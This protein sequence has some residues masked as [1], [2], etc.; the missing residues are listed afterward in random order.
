MAK[1]KL[2]PPAGLTEAE[3]AE[4]WY[5]HRDQTDEIFDGPE[6]PIE[7]RRNVTISVR[8]SDAEIAE[9]R[10][11]ADELGVKVTALIRAAALEAT[12]PV[13]LVAIGQAVTELE[14]RTHQLAELV[15][16]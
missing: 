14:R 5:E 4:W 12:Q 11:H 15:S 13:D 6:E 8:F 7:V 3:E 10:A 1:T 9:L 2:R 16:R